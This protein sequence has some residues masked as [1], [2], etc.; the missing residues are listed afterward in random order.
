[1]GN[2]NLSAKTIGGH[3][4]VIDKL[5]LKL[6]AKAVQALTRGLKTL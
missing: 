6:T 4:L 3:L 5:V 1:M 2:I